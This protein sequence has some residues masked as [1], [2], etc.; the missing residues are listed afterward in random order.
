MSKKHKPHQSA[1]QPQPVAHKNLPAVVNAPEASSIADFPL[2]AMQMSFRAL[3]QN[4]ELASKLMTAREVGDVLSLQHDFAHA[5]AESLKAETAELNDL[6]L[7]MARETAE[8]MQ[9]A[10]IKSMKDWQRSFAA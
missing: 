3:E 9:S 4:L 5:R 7:R 1:A 8:T 2:R 6:A 10:F